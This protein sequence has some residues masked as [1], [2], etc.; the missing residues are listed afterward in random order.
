MEIGNILN[1]ILVNEG[2]RSAMLIQPSD[3][4]E[5]T[6]TD[7]K[8]LSIVN[9]IKKLF[10]DLVS[11]DTYTTYQGTIISKKSFDGKFL[12]PLDIFLLLNRRFKCPKV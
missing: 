9:K 2:V 11:S 12:L 1:A 7:T 6:G 10:P 3:Y 4:K 8:T 5:R